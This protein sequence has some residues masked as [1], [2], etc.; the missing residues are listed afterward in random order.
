MTAWS[1]KK[2]TYGEV[3][4]DIADR[5]LVNGRLLF[6]TM[7]VVFESTD[8]DPSLTM[9]L[10]VR[11]D[12]PQCRSLCIT[13]RDDGR[14][15]SP[16]DIAAVDLPTWVESLFT[17]ESVPAF[18]DENGVIW[19]GR[20]DLHS[21]GP[22]GDEA[23][24]KAMKPI[25]EARRRRGPRKLDDAHYRKVAEVYREHVDRSP[26]KAVAEIFGIERSM[27][28]KYVRGARDRKFLGPAQRGKAGEH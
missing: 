28:E 26:T 17:A 22:A 11:D 23:W 21:A 25:R 2:T 4:Y 24:R 16:L 5:V 7:E 27:A 12:R 19:L 15:V 14:E 8:G 13:A 10:E 1:R 20:E 9:R 3:A 6:R 18:R